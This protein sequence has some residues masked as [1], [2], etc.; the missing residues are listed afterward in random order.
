MTTAVISDPMSEVQR[1]SEEPQ[2][3]PDAMT[4]KLAF[5]ASVAQEVFWYLE[6][7]QQDITAFNVPIRFRITGSLNVDLLEKS[8]HAIIDRHEALRT[9]FAED[10]G[11]LLQIVEPEMRVG[12]PVTDLTHLPLE[13]AEKEAVRL[14]AIE[15]KRPF[16]LHRQPLIRFELLR[17]SVDS[18]ILHLTVHHALFDGIS[19]GVI[20]RELAAFY[21]AFHDGKPDP[22]EPL[23]IQ[24]GDYSIWQKEFLESRAVEPQLAYWKKRLHGMQELDL[25]TDRPR[26]PVKSWQ[27]EIISTLLPRQLTNR[28]QEI[29]SRNGAT[30][31]H[32]HLAA[33]NVLLHRYS[34]STDIAVG[35]P[36]TGRTRGEL[37]PLIG[38]F[39]NSVIIRTDLSGDP[40]F[41]D[42][43]RQ[44]RDTTIGALEN[45]DLP[46]EHLVRELKP[47]RDPS[48]NPLFQVNFSHHRSFV[49][50]EHFG[51][52]SLVSIPSVSPGTIFDLHF[53]L[54]ERT[55]GWRASCDFSTDLFDVSTAWRMLGH[56][57]R[58][59]EEIAAEPAKPIS[60]LGILTPGE[61]AEIHNHGTGVPADF[62]RGATIGGLFTETALKHPE[63]I[64][65]V[66]GDRKI[67]Y[68]ELHSEA[69]ATAHRLRHAGVKPGDLVGICSRPSP[70]TISGLIGIALAGGAY[71][72]LDPDY[73]SGRFKMLLEESGIRIAL[74]ADGCEEP[75]AGWNGSVVPLTGNSPDTE[76]LEVPVTAEHPAYLLFTSGS[77]G[78]P[79]G[80]LVPHRAV[81]RLVRG[82][83]YV[84]VHEDD[85]FLQTAP[86]SFD[87][88]TFEIWTPLLNG[89]R[90][91]LPKAGAGLGDFAS[92]IR[93]HGVT[94]LWLTSGLFQ[95]MIEEHPE[96]L[97]NVRH[98]LTGGEAISALHVRKTLDA[99][100][101]TDLI[102]VYGPTENTT[103]TT[104][105]RITREDLDRP[106]I[107]IGR[108]IANTTVRILDEEGRIVPA[109][110]PGEL[111]TGGDGLAIGYHDS[112]ALTGEKFIVH[113]EFG[114]LYKTGDLCRWT[115]DG[116]IEFLG[117]RD[118]QVKVRGYRIELGEIETAIA[119]QPGV[120]QAKVAVRGEDTSGKRILAWVVLEENASPDTQSLQ[121]ALSSKLPSF[122]LPEAI[123][124]VDAL[125]VNAN[126][127]IDV[128]A[129]PDPAPS[130]AGTPAPAAR[131]LPEG[132]TENALAA[133]WRDLL[134]RPEIGRDDDFFALGGHSLLALRMFSRIH[135]E[136]GKSLPL[137]ALLKHPTIAS[138][139]AVLSEEPQDQD[140]K[141]HVVTLAEGAP[142]EPPLF[143]IHGGDGGVL[144]YRDIASRLPERLPI[145]AI[146]SLELAHSREIV[147]ASVSETATAYVATLLAKFPQGP[148]RLAGYSFGGVVAQE[149]ACQL[150]EAGHRIEL[151]WLFD[152]DNPAA[153]S[154]KYSAM[155]RLRVFWKQNSDL[156]FSKRISRLQRRILDGAETNRRTREEIR[157]AAASGP[158]EPYSDLRRVQVREENWRAMQEHTPRL[159]DGKITLFKAEIG[160][161]KVE[162]EPDYGWSSCTSRGLEIVSLPGDHLTAFDSENIPKLAATLIRSLEKAEASSK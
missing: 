87:A 21:Q 88:S 102:H 2:A 119:S 5:P 94:T 157:A 161:D 39:I 141:G 58:L 153:K 24:Y 78:R 112:P 111:H 117:R 124:I 154:R 115:A 28:L 48:R 29:A 96:S 17:L 95:L 116:F 145:H 131:H 146:E 79:K 23:A 147:P 89:G 9:H 20:T 90:I 121:T 42:L 80:V 159:F 105:H 122:M 33:Y 10:K 114:R 129:L 92:A 25:P 57:V 47:D 144:F 31:F 15:A 11:E 59:M 152:T 130:S 13:E 67:T 6:M 100:P 61:A 104:F 70:E 135:R 160:S 82:C 125:P 44:V 139:A 99:L 55:E 148:F 54:V 68:R 118:H 151:L 12:L 38:V 162:Y 107:P 142:G 16:R 137:A 71:V 155:E 74:A 45:Q 36:V 136:F 37:E 46:F 85:V 72:P 103:F 93:D 19:M 81:V 120:K 149:M 150:A 97:R 3:A 62:P 56:F 140:A 60:R 7:I 158:A 75:F 41:E 18:C 32:L 132:E 22:L 43:V 106:L 83:D 35:M 52:V 108:P 40:V 123:G 98:I 91:V 128:H 143:C 8:I 65:L 26:P 34:G 1:A 49:E 53:F 14:G 63:R 156:S 73:P 109:G 138:L 51:G 69:L 101:H 50:D 113:P 77:T 4:G 134:G 110:I 76:P 86:L 126:G 66:S 133:I 84:P 27:G 127:K 30:L 64:A